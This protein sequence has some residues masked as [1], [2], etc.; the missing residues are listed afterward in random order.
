MIIEYEIKDDKWL[1]KG[2]FDT[3]GLKCRFSI[4]TDNSQAWIFFDGMDIQL[5]YVDIEKAKIV[6][7]KFIEVIWRSGSTY[8]K[9]ELPEIGY[10]QVLDYLKLQCNCDG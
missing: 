1:H 3:T 5:S 4:C 9:F 6:Y 10:I 7:N 8:E 2:L